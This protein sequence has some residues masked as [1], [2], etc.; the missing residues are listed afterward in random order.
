MS[1]TDWDKNLINVRNDMHNLEQAPQYEIRAK[2]G[3]YRVIKYYGRDYK[4]A[5]VLVRGVSKEVAE[6]YIKLLKG[7]SK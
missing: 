3:K 5:E 7:E 4:D 2:Y 1:T 6:G